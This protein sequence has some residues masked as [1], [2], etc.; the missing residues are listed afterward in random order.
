MLANVGDEI[1]TEPF[2]QFS[3]TELEER[4]RKMKE[5]IRGI[6]GGFDED[7][8][9]LVSQNYGFSTEHEIDD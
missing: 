3:N 8:T 7:D 4:I 2:N 9:D 6:Q 1:E 5:K